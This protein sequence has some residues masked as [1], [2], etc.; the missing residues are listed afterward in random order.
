MYATTIFI[1]LSLQKL[2]LESAKI[3]PILV[4]LK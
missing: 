1:D 4:V 2:G 3:R